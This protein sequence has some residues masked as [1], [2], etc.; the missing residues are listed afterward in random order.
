MIGDEYG[1][2]NRYIKV[3]GDVIFVEMTR[4]LVL[5]NIFV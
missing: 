1:D 3:D 5:D 2:I 4:T